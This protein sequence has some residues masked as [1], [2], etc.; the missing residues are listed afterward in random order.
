MQTTA[1]SH[2]R[3][4]LGAGQYWNREGALVATVV[5]E[6]LVVEFDWRTHS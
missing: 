5:Q 6:T 3:G 1:I 4:S 2:L